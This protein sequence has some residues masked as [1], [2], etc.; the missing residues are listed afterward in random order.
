[1]LESTSSGSI[2]I[3]LQ[4]GSR[5]ETSNSYCNSSTSSTVRRRHWEEPV[6]L[7]EKKLETNGKNKGGLC[8]FMTMYKI[9]YFL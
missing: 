7:S 5:T 4:A 2:S 8:V 3:P 6:T 9:M 1:M